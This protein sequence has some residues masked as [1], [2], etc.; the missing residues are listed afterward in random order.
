MS[1]DAK[2]SKSKKLNKVLERVTIS[3]NLKEKLSSLCNQANE[4]LQGI[5]TVTKS[6]IVN[7]IL[8]NHS[9]ILSKNEIEDLKAEH[10]DELRFANWL[11]S[12]IRDARENGESVSLKDLLERSK[13]LMENMK[14]QA[15]KRRKRHKVQT[16]ECEFQ[17]GDIVPSSN[18]SDLVSKE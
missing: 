10:F 2:G 12:K 11:A 9:E 4:S 3:E 6:D 5:A 18:E 7:L 13:P 16:P 15:E 17:S 14:V 1:E 8:K